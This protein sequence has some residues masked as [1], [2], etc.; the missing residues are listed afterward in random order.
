MQ[1]LSPSVGVQFD[2]GAGAMLAQHGR[3][4][5]QHK[6]GHRGGSLV[7]RCRQGARTQPL[8]YSQLISERLMLEDGQG[9]WRQGRAGG[10]EGRRQRSAAV[11]FDSV[12]ACGGKGGKGRWG[13]E[14]G[15]VMFTDL[16]LILS[17]AP[18]SPAFVPHVFC[19]ISPPASFIASYLL[20]FAFCHR[21]SFHFPHFYLCSTPVC[22]QDVVI[23][24]LLALPLLSPSCH[25]S[26]LHLLPRPCFITPEQCPP[27]L[28]GLVV[29]YV[30]VGY[31]S[32]CLSFNLQI[33][34]SN[35]KSPGLP[36]VTDPVCRNPFRRDVRLLKKIPNF[37]MKVARIKKLGVGP[38][39]FRSASQ[40]WIPSHV[41]CLAPHSEIWYEC[42]FLCKHRRD[43]GRGVSYFRFCK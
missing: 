9:K 24:F 17:L 20:L 15:D 22:C 28:Q 41:S 40:C 34:V 2:L 8:W 4:L 42:F 19:L 12:T 5:R 6:V 16:F 3:L 43:S 29:L 18:V 14:G 30:H 11:R 35:A 33:P 7:G 36:A 31:G 1:K 27:T 10:R 32:L 23:H 25:F 37:Q 38:I 39:M 13:K 26:P 21:L